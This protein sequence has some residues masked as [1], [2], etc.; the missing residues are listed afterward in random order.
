MIVL[1]LVALL[2]GCTDDGIVETRGTNLVGIQ[3]AEGNRTW[4]EYFIYDS[5]GLLSEVRDNTPLER[6]IEL[7][8]TNER[9]VG[10]LYFSTEPEAIVQKIP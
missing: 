7:V 6:K 3:Y 2:L 8:Y 4:T 1:P 10:I 5:E 9:P